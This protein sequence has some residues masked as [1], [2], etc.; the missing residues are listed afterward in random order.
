MPAHSC[1]TPSGPKSVGRVRVPPLGCA[2]PPYQCPASICCNREFK[3]SRCKDER[4]VPESSVLIAALALH[5]FDLTLS[6][7][8]GRTISKWNPYEPPKP[9]FG[10][11]RAP[12]QDEFFD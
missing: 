8:H 6:S 3:R 9:L 10:L 5:P 4:P 7:P 1:A 12:N 11:A 2:S